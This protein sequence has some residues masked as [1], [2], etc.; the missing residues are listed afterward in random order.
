V[1]ELP[2]EAALSNANA[3]LGTPHF[4]SPEQCSGGKLDIRSDLYSLGVTLWEMI[5]GAVPFTGSATQVMSQHLTAPLP[6][7]KLPAVPKPLVGLLKSLLQKDP[8]N[9]RYAVVDPDGI[10]GSGTQTTSGYRNPTRQS[11][12]PVS[13]TR[14]S[15]NCPG[16]E[17]RGRC[18]APSP[19]KTG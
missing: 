17:N 16:S 9:D 4:A 7:E 11:G 1:E 3:F 8:Q 10:T 18:P 14:L 2:K 12:D 13:C 19:S 5:A 15:A 6:L